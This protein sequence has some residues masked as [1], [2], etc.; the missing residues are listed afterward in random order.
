MEHLKLTAKKGIFLL[1]ETHFEDNDK[2][3]IRHE[4]GTEDFFLCNGER[5]SRGTAI[6]FSNLNYKILHNFSD[7]GRLQILALELL[8]YNKKV[9]IVNIYNENNEKAQ[10]RLL[11]KLYK[12]MNE[13]PNL[14]DFDIIIG[15]DWNCFLNRDLD[16]KYGNPCTKI[17]TIAEISKIKTKFDLIDIFRVNHPKLKRYSWSRPS[18]FTL[19]RLDFFLISNSLMDYVAVSDILPSHLSDHR[20]VRI[21]FEP[22]NP[23]PRGAGI[24]KFNSTY[25]KDPEFMAKAN[26]F[27]EKVV[28]D[29]QNLDPKALFELIKFKFKGFAREIALENAKKCRKEE[30]DLTDKI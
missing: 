14:P 22:L 4:W 28:H 18:P 5:D 8:E 26:V 27:L 13:V 12:K 25:L 6:F 29:F 17:K 24:W 19:R 11:E 21:R 10:V 1:Q 15:G 16:C 20:P 23:L 30:K 3:I 2:K 7:E 9:L